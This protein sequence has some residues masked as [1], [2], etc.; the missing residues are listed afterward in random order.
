MLLVVLLVFFMLSSIGSQDPSPCSFNPMCS[1]RYSE[2]N[3]IRDVSCMGVPFSKSPDLPP[4][5]VSHVDI[6]DSG[7]EVLDDLGASVEAL[8]LVTNKIIYLTNNS[9]TSMSST[10][11]TLDLSHNQLQEVPLG[12]LCSLTG[13]YWINLFGNSITGLPRQWCL[14]S[15]TLT[16]LFLGE[17]DLH[18]L[19]F[20]LRNLTHLEWITLD[21]NKLRSV[22]R[23]SLPTSL[24][25]LSVQHNLLAD[26]PVRTVD[27]MTNLAR[28]FLRGNA[29]SRIPPYSFRKKKM[30]DKLD[31]GENRL[32]DLPSTWFNNSITIR[33]L[34]LEF[35]NIKL[36]RDYTFRSLNLGRVVLGHNRLT[37]ISGNVFA[38]LE[39]SLE[40]VDLEGNMIESIA[41]A[42]TRLRV[43]KF[44]YLANNKIS[45]L[46][47]ADF[48]TFAAHL[49]ALSL[50][51]NRLYHIPNEAFKNLRQ[52][53]HLNLGYNQISEIN[54]NDFDGWGA[55]LDT[56]LLMNNRISYLSNYLFRHTQSL[57]ELSLSF[58]QIQDMEPHA[59]IDVARTLESLEISFGLI[60]E[61][62]PEDAL[63]PLSSLLWLSVD[64][65]NIREMHRTSLYTFGNL[66][67][68]NLDFN[69]I[70]YLPEGM[71][72][73]LIHTH[74][75]DLRIAY[76]LLTKIGTE[77]FSS[78]SD[79]QTVVLTGNYIRYIDQKAFKELPNLL[80]V[81][82][83]NNNLVKISPQAF[84]NAPK[85]LRLDLQQNDLRYFTFDAFI[86]TS[87]FHPMTLNISHNRITD[88]YCT[89]KKPFMKLKSLDLSH[90]A[91]QDIPSELLQLLSGYLR[92]LY[93]G[94]NKIGGLSPNVFNNLSLQVLTLNHNNI[95]EL[96][97]GT[98]F[99]LHEL[100]ILNLSFNKIKF[101]QSGLFSNLTRLRVLRLAHNHLK[102]VT[103]KMFENTVLEKLD[104]SHNEILHV[105]DLENVKSTMRELDLSFNYLEY[106][107][108]NVFRKIPYLTTLNLCNNRLTI[109]P[110]NVFSGLNNLL[111]LRICSNPLRVKYRDLF[112]F[113]PALRRLDL[114]SVSL[115][116]V[117]PLKLPLLV[118]L[119]LT[120]NLIQEFPPTSG[121]GLP[122]LRT[123]LLKANHLSEIPQQVWYRLPLL[124]E[125]DLSTNP[126]KVINSTSL[127]GLRHL[128]S[129][130]LTDLPDLERVD[131]GSLSVLPSLMTL[132]VS[133]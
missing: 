2:P 96:R 70:S 100:Q 118:H 18:E 69:R 52:L 125:L 76:N 24:H 13:L 117:P 19:D 17:N 8:R 99:G 91:I 116:S 32:T 123:L 9:L 45:R 103:A 43:L 133:S 49:K 7:L 22:Q 37:N 109:L 31:L 113:T 15:S 79:L 97:R 86:N 28:L 127:S 59:F 85:L 71:F 61:E 1:C 57:R 115:T 33:D 110:T 26:I 60:G 82:L 73:S 65:N 4:S 56:L 75:R 77:T 35:N 46:Q 111:N 130:V 122:R 108:N 34:N 51:G 84:F 66:K 126:I 83:T 121:D 53:A 94:N 63:R 6:V 10:L 54:S 104:L 38:G 64:N 74:L 23:G 16:N 41:N 12:A 3:T 81:L 90:N 39:D 14:L 11:R 132:H 42:F 129:L 36:L 40:Y 48:R 21:H 29:I 67:Y 47:D 93:L 44:L 119:N 98:F 87:I 92:T 68:L 88:V 106:L 114:S 128:E 25:T 30:L 131:S 89:Y 78:L 27:Q 120:D 95:D 62:F 50:S 101:L 72:N 58:N 5:E 55:H 105:P 80:T 124:K 112:N 107:E 102:S 20:S